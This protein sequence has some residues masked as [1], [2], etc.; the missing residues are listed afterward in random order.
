MKFISR[1]NF[2]ASYLRSRFRKKRNV[3]EKQIL[4]NEEAP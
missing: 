1:I 3:L 2:I 4:Y